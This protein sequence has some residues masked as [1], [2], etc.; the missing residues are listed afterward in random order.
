MATEP[1]ME[2]GGEKLSIAE[3]ERRYPDEWV[4]IVDYDF[5]NMILTAG[6]VHAHSRDRESLRPIIRSL[7]DRAVRWTGKKT[8]PKLWVMARRD[9]DRLI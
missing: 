5:P 9:V 4:V 2:A 8:N 3:I 7:R 6:I 1:V